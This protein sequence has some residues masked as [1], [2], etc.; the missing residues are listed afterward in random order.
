MKKLIYIVNGRVPTEKAN[1]YQ[2]TKMCQ[3]FSSAG[4]AVELYLP[5][6]QNPIRE[7]LFDF[8]NLP[9]DFA[10]RYLDCPD[11]IVYKKY[12]GKFCFWLQALGFLIT[13]A[14]QKPDRA[15]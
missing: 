5:T 9:R 14:R 8:Y 7:N 1:G 11:F 3:E 10:C 6:R 12:L 2:I 4:L 15:S 13:L